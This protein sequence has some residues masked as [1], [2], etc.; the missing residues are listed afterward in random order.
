MHIPFITRTAKSARATRSLTLLGV[1][2]LL[3]ALTAYALAAPKAPTRPPSD[4]TP[5]AIAL[6]FPADGGIYGAARWADACGGARLCGSADDPSGVASVS[7]SVRRV[8]TGLYWNGSAFASARELFLTASGTTTWRLSLPLPPEGSY[9]V[10]V[11]ASDKL[12]NATPAGAELTAT[13]TIDLQPPP[14]PTI[15]DGP[16]S[17][18]NS[19]VATFTLTDSEAGVSFVCKLDYE[20]DYRACDA[21]P[22]FSGVR[23]GQRTLSVRALD[24]AGNLSTAAAQWTW[25]VDTVAPPRPRIVQKPTDPSTSTSAAFGFTDAESGV[26]FECRLD[27]GAWTGCTSPKAYSGLAA[28]R[29]LFA[30]RAL[31]AA[32]NH[33]DAAEYAWSVVLPAGGQPFTLAGGL[34]GGLLLSPGRSGALAL[35]VTNPN[36]VAI[37]VTSLTVTIQPGSTR[38]GCD[39]LGNLTVTQSNASEANPLSVPAH[40]TVTLPAGGVSA[41]QIAM[42]NL[43]TNQ[44]AC[45]GA[46]FTFSFSGSAHS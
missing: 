14:A 7:L 20:R 42:L 22:T 12:G 2:A 41:P 26:A 15:V 44:D 17:L 8:A 29:H 3:G 10:R 33:S 6:S 46:A 1:L 19:A 38:A 28:G 39:G 34:A 24:R 16:P 23:D 18:T 11:R 43:S 21:H 40:G 35:R 30:V 27:A 13:F 9:V 25:R 31:D 45:K 32:G 36:D 5:P 37:F 4:T